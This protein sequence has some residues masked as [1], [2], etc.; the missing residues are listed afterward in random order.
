MMARSCK[1]CSAVC[2]RPEIDAQ[3]PLGRSLT[4]VA[5]VAIS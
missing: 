5:T 4:L 2:R 1:I 3:L